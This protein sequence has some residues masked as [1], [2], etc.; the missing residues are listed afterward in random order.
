MLEEVGGGLL[1]GFSQLGAV[2]CPAPDVAS[3]GGSSSDPQTLVFGTRSGQQAL[4][5][6]SEGILDPG[7][8]AC[9]GLLPVVSLRR[10][11]IQ[12]ANPQDQQPRRD[13]S[14]GARVRLPL[15][16]QQPTSERVRT[17]PRGYPEEVKSAL[18][19]CQSSWASHLADSVPWASWN[20]RSRGRP[21]GGGNVAF[22]SM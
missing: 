21:G 10:R 12:P 18:S 8:V 15:N 13:R 2:L 14:T 9:R 19:S 1:N 4:S 11:R 17:R 7:L 22:P 20:S 6:T 3:A 16:S 5:N